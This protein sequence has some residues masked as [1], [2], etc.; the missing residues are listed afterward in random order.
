MKTLTGL[1]IDHSQAVIIA[2]SGK[3]EMFKIVESNVKK[4][5]RRTGDSILKGSFEPL[6]VPA[7]DS[8]QKAFSNYLNSYY[9]EVI[10]S[11]VDAESV[12][13]LGPGEAKGELKN[14]MEET[15]QDIRI[16]SVETA[17]K[18]TDGQLVAHVREFFKQ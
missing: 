8:R 5:L 18:M 17:S 14:R 2:I 11:L 7:D 10:S 1:W 3:E 15:K 4:Q 12:L 13:I 16:A 6:Q 9:D